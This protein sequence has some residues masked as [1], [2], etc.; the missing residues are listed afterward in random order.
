MGYT[1]GEEILFSESDNVRRLESCIATSPEGA[2]LLQ[3][4]VD[5]FVM[6]GNQ[7]KQYMSLGRGAS[8]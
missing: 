3:V 2:A 5:E 7:Q 6:M 1:L 4:N 8:M